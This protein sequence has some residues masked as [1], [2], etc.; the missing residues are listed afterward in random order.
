MTLARSDLAK[1][2]AVT[3]IDSLKMNKGLVHLN[4]AKCPLGSVSTPALW[5]TV[6][7]SAEQKGVAAVFEYLA[8]N[9]TL[10]SL[11]LSGIPVPVRVI[12]LAR[13]LTVFFR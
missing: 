9:R 3:L 7:H 13:S 8:S 1:S 6:P 5:R 2:A 12:A 4:L 11:K 10:I